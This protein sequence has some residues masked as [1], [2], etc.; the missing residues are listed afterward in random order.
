MEGVHKRAKQ[1]KYLFSRGKA[2]KTGKEDFQRRVI[3]QQFLKEWFRGE[4]TE[5]KHVK[6]NVNRNVNFE[7]QGMLISHQNILIKTL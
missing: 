5:N 1:G 3:T 2:G 4:S 6:A 7:S